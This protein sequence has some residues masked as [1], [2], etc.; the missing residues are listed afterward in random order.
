MDFLGRAS[1]IK[2]LLTD[3]SGAE[4]VEYALVLGLVAIAAIGAVT[5]VGTSA[6]AIWTSISGTLGTAAG[7]T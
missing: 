3:E 1:N 4:M 2:R 5:A 6:N 7:G